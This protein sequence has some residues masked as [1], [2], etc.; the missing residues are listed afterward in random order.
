ML[1]TGTEASAYADTP[2]DSVNPAQAGC[3]TDDDSNPSRAVGMLCNHPGARHRLVESHRLV[4][5]VTPT[6]PVIRPA[7]FKHQK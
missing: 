2:L 5:S 4:D 6:G 7:S 1:V 3:Y